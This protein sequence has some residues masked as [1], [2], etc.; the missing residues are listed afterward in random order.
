MNGYTKNKLEKMAKIERVTLDLLNQFPIKTIAMTD[1]A[2]AAGV[3][4]VTIFNYYDSKQMLIKKVIFDHF[5]MIYDQYDRIV[6]SDLSFEAAY[7]AITQF[8]LAAMQQ[9][10][11]CLNQNIMTL[12]ATD[13]TFYDQAA[14]DQ[15][16]QLMLALIG[17]GRTD[18][19]INPRYSDDTILSL[20]QIYS[21][22][23]KIFGETPDKL[24]AMTDDLTAI[25][26]NGLR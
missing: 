26:L 23:M 13:P 9:N 5:Q 11:A 14:R 16:Q 4:K 17:K 7:R 19:F 24:L 3:S 12:Y 18:G 6:S 15:S 10:T 22:G 2:Q 1:I 21:E 20:F 25:F 8:Q